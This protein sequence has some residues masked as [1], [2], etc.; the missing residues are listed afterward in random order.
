MKTNEKTNIIR[1]ETKAPELTDEELKRAAG[2][3]DPT[4]NK[5]PELTD[6]EPERAAGGIVTR[7]EPSDDDPELNHNL[8]P[9]DP[10][11]RF[12]STKK[13]TRP[14]DTLK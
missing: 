7:L 9:A 10:I 12:D 5:T 4:L 6:E 14:I 3:S 8:G 11:R 2:G 13:P 1:E